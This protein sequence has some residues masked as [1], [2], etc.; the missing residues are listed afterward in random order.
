MGYFQRANLNHCTTHVIYH[1]LYDMGC[2]VTEV[3]SCD[4]PRYAESFRSVHLPTPFYQALF[5]SEGALPLSHHNSFT[6]CNTWLSATTR[7]EGQGPTIAEVWL[8]IRIYLTPSHKHMTTLHNSLLQT[9]TTVTS[10]LAQLGSGFQ[11]SNSGC[12]LSSRFPNCP[13]ASATVIHAH[14]NSSWRLHTLDTSHYRLTC[15]SNLPSW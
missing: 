1:Q 12:F 14:T 10:A 9:Y 3:S 5:H 4:K 11:A 2:Q 15:L 7:L 6:T 8:G 13:L